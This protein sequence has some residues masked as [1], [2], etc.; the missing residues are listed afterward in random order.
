MKDLQDEVHELAVAVS[1]QA[2]IL[3][4]LRRM[5]NVT[6]EELRLARKDMFEVASNTVHTVNEVCK[7]TKKEIH[8]DVEKQVIA[9]QGTQDFKNKNLFFMLP[10]GVIGQVVRFYGIFS[11]CVLPVLYLYVMLFK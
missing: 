7:E 3:E 2:A 11:L 8:T 10:D 9:C 4:E 6:L 1:S 5:Q